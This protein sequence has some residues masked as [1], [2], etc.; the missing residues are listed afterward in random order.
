MKNAAIQLQTLTCLIFLLP[1]LPCQSCIAQSL[2]NDT[3]ATVGSEAIASKQFLQRYELMPWFGKENIAGVERTKL[4]FLY[5]LVAEKLLSFGARDFGIGEDTVTKEYIRELESMLVRDQLYRRE[6]R[7]KITVSDSEVSAGFRKVPWHL[8]VAA[9]W[10]SSKEY[11]D[12][13]FRSLSVAQNPDSLLR[14]LR[15]SLDVESDTLI[16]SWN[17]AEEHI[18]DVAYRLR[19]MEFSSPLKTD[20]GFVILR[21]LDKRTDPEFAK[22]STS[23]QRRIVERALRARKEQDLATSYFYSLLS[24]KRGEADRILFKILSDSIASIVAKKA[25]A[26]TASGTPIYLTSDDVDTLVAMLHSYLDQAYISYGYGLLTTRQVLERMR[27]E[28]FAVR[29][30]KWETVAARLNRYNRTIIQNELLADE[31]YRLKLQYAEDVQND[32]KM[33]TENRRASLL[34]QRILDTVRVTEQDIWNYYRAHQKEFESPIEVNIREILV[35]SLDLAQ[36]LYNRIQQGED[37]AELARRYSVRKGISQRGGEFGF[38]PVTENGA[39]G[40]YASFL[41]VGDLFGPIR[42]PEGYSIFRLLAKREPLQKKNFEEV[43]K[44]SSGEG[45]EGKTSELG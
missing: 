14:L 35:D 24:P 19:P 27:I 22:A 36:Q 9:F 34:I 7:D 2:T 1:C 16:L 10:S 17:T 38:F 44:C 20:T 30:R 18:E 13:L 40:M 41:N 37:M 15:N 31:G 25:T 23:D 32:V 4:E 39:L 6:V 5:S 3:L 12:A 21:L 33:W 45:F 28:L 29:S 11:L 26:D 42:L 43:S 8:L